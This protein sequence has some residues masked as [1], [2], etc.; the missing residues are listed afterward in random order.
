MHVFDT[1]YGKC[2]MLLVILIT[3]QTPDA[4]SAEQLEAIMQSKQKK[5]EV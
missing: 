4:H 2:V 1:I 5:N 3:V